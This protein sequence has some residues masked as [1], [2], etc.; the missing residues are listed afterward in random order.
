MMLM[1]SA[2]GC[3]ATIDFEF[4][5]PIAGQVVEIDWNGS[6]ISE[7]KSAQNEWVR[8]SFEVNLQRGSNQLSFRYAD[9]NGRLDRFSTQDSR[10]MAVR[11]HAVERSRNQG[12]LSYL[13]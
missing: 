10:P 3:G 8:R 2:H 7:I 5:N 13:L 12:T 9:W 11:F 1:N 6:R 4:L